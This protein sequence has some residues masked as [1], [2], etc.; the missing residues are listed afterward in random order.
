M[1]GMPVLALSQPAPDSFSLPACKDDAD[2]LENKSLREGFLD[3][4]IFFSVSFSLS[5]KL[6]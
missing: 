4:S 6:L 1:K 5:L 3:L 2:R